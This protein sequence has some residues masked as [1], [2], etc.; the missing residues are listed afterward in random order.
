M[1]E[2]KYKNGLQTLTEPC[3][4]SATSCCSEQWW[5]V[6]GWYGMQWGLKKF[7]GIFKTGKGWHTEVKELKRTDQGTQDFL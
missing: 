2:S 4:I 5:Q 3:K 1:T 6:I 7:N